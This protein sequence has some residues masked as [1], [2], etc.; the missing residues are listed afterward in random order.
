MISLKNKTLL[1][2]E[3]VITINYMQIK[4]S[5]NEQVKAPG[6]FTIEWVAEAS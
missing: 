4:E 1:K 3:N 6:L 5:I 2:N